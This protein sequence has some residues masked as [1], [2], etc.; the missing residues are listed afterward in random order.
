MCIPLTC[1][2]LSRTLSLSGRGWPWWADARAALW[3]VQFTPG[4][5]CHLQ[6]NLPASTTSK[7]FVC[8][9]YVRKYSNYQSP[10]WSLQIIYCRA[11]REMIYFGDI[12][13]SWPSINSPPNSIVGIPITW[14]LCQFNKPTHQHLLKG[15]K[16]WTIKCWK[17]FDCE[18]HFPSMNCMN[19][20]YD[21]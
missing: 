9:Q 5:N 10:V 13:N 17:S 8:W 11:P 7:Y 20:T 4:E 18:A 14:A 1:G 19:W 6:M 15:N 2:V 21:S 3:R 16:K 12:P